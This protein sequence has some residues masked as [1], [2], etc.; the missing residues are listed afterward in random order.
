MVM[1]FKNRRIEVSY[2]TQDEFKC[3]CC[4]M[5]N[6]SAW[7]IHQLNRVRELYGKPMIVNSGC[8]CRNHNSH[9]GGSA[10]SEHLIGTAADIKCD[11]SHD[12]YLLI[13]YAIQVGFTRIGVSKNFIHLG[14]STQHPG[15][16]LWV[17]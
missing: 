10:N 2:F 9:V 7:L 11:N 4:G 16:V 5:V 13:K 6:V 3:P 15:E 12:R 1:P 17:Y 8:R 14:V